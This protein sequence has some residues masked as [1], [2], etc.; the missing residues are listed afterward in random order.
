[1]THIFIILHFLSVTVGAVLLVHTFYHIPCKGREKYYYIAQGCL[2]MYFLLDTMGIYGRHFLEIRKILDFL[3]SLNN[4]LF[5]VG[6]VFL[7]LYIISI[8][9]KENTKVPGNLLAVS[10]LAAACQLLLLLGFFVE[11]L[12]Q[13]PWACLFYLCFCTA[14]FLYTAYFSK[15]RMEKAQAFQPEVRAVEDEEAGKGSA[16]AAEAVEGGEGLAAAAEAVE[17]GE[18][19]ATAE[20][21]VEEGE[22][23]ASE[24]E[25]EGRRKNLTAVVEAV[26]GG[27]DLAAAVEAREKEEEAP[28]EPDER[29]IQIL[30]KKF[31][32][33]EQEVFRLLCEGKNNREIGEL[34]FISANTVRNHVYNIYRKAG[35]KN[36]I[37]LVNWAKAV[38]QPEQ[39]SASGSASG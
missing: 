20:E 15:N 16:A 37:E 14:G 28:E 30:G 39:Q 13:V 11:P 5:S 25:A 33:R 34:L 9:W 8:K 19:L 22:G 12:K 26:E 17:E 38:S 35:V 1:M 32:S 24:V 10:G 4:V 31:T 3:R 21:D 7:V 18:G 2:G 36:R 29:E 27:E 23:S 6:M